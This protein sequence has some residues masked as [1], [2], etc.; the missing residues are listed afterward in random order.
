MKSINKILMKAK[1]KNY[2]KNI[3]RVQEQVLDLNNQTLKCRPITWIKLIDEFKYW[4]WKDK[5]RAKLRKEM[6]M[7]SKLEHCSVIGSYLEF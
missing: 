1:L 2:K 5:E 7:Q 4:N 6:L 3:K